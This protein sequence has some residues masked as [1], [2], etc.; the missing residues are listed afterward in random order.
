MKKIL[1]IILA[2]LMVA[3]LSMAVFAAETEVPYDSSWVI[4]VSSEHTSNLG[5]LKAFDGDESTYWHTKF[6][7]ENNQVT[8]HDE[9]PHIIT[10]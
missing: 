4:T 9:V 1:S 6:Y 5:I 3:S 10:V 8:G 7:V 2:L